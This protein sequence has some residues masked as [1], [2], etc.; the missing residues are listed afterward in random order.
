M[1]V[2]LWKG[3]QILLQTT[4]IIDVAIPGYKIII[5]K[6]KEEIE[7]YHNLKREIQ[8]LCHL[9]KVDEIPMVLG[10][11]WSVTKNFESEICR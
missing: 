10:A 2:S 9:K 3:N 8:R 7:K 6:E 1:T 11:L 5:D 4:L